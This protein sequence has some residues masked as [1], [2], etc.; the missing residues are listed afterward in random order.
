MKFQD[1]GDAIQR[2]TGVAT[3]KMQMR[4]AGLANDGELLAYLAEHLQSKTGLHPSI[5]L[6]VE[7]ALSEHEEAIR[8]LENALPAEIELSLESLLAAW[9]RLRPRIEGQTV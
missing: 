4:N 2:R 7:I 9:S 8:A 3:D 1:G 5:L 6:E